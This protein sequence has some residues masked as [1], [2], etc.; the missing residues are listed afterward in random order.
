VLIDAGHEVILLRQ[1]LAPN[2]PDPLVAAVSQMNNAVLVSMDGDFRSLAPRAGIG[3]NRFLRL[4]RI[5]LRCSE[6]RAAGRMNAAMSLIEHEWE[7]AQSSSD[8]R[9]IV[10]IG[11]SYMRTIR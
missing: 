4:S 8:K 7:V 2:S 11:T 9:M 1:Q 6:P 3:R 5:A 10:E